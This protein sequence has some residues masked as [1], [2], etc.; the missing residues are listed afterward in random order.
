MESEL[1]YCLLIFR[2]QE[3]WT[4]C[5][6]LKSAECWQQLATAALRSLDIDF[7]LFCYYFFVTDDCCF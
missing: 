7:G 5:D 3:A 4:L 1:Q 6:Q 2:F